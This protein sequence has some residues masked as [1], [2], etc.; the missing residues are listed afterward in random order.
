VIL[1]S[2]CGTEVKCVVLL[3][4]WSA[5]QPQLLSRIFHVVI[6][7]YLTSGADFDSLDSFE[8][9][10][11]GDGLP[12]KSSETNL[13]SLGS[14]NSQ[15]IA[16]SRPVDMPFPSPHHHGSNTSLNASGRPLS[17]T[18]YV[19]LVLSVSLQFFNDVKV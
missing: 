2:W 11:Y 3:V 7:L 8:S 13:S 14:S 5:V 9:S 17:T 1:Y 19:I 16:S 10:I 4:S 18:Q 6:W 15:S 12:R